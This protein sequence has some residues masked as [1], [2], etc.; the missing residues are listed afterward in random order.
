MSEIVGYVC[1]S[2][3]FISLSVM[4]SMSI[5]TVTKGKIF[6][7]PRSIP[8]FNY[9]VVVLSTH[10]LIDTGTIFHILVIVNNTEMNIGVLMFFPISILVPFGYIYRSGIT[11]SKD[12][13]T[14]NFLRYL[15]TV[16]CSDCASL[17][18]HQQCQRAP[19]SPHPRQHLFVDLMM[20]AILAGVR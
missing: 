16:L 15:H 9:P 2:D 11:G 6:L 18:S 1:S 4:F 19:L 12:R 7:L 5:H 14:F 20:M 3:W 8:L 17:H 10:L 13:S